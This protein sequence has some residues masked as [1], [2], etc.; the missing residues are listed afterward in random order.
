MGRVI[1]PIEI[2]NRGLFGP[3][4]VHK[5]IVIEEDENEIQYRFHHQSSS[6]DQMSFDLNQN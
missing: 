1:D 3:T 5:A 2:E 6:I 4:R